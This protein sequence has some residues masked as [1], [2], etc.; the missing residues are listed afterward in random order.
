MNS[1]RIIALLAAAVLA[2][3]VTGCAD[4][5]GGNKDSNK[6]ADTQS[7]QAG[8]EDKDAPEVP[9]DS[10]FDE[11]LPQVAFSLESGFYDSDGDFKAYTPQML[12]HRYM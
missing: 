2:I 1:K 6:A 5:S 11:N 3:S 9:V 10:T 4:S 8:G 7:A 12:N